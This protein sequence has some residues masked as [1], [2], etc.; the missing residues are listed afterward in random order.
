[1]N[2]TERRIYEKKMGKKLVSIADNIIK[3]TKKYEETNPQKLEQLITDEI[4]SLSFSEIMLV[5]LYIEETLLS[6]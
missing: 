5:T 3:W 6:D 2:R 4:K 1:M